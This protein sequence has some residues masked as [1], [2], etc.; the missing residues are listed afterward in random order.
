[1]P[2]PKLALAPSFCLGV[3]SLHRSRSLCLTGRPCP[4]RCPLAQASTFPA[5]GH[6]SL[7]D[8]TPARLP[9][10]PI[11][12]HCS[13]VSASGLPDPSGGRRRP[14]AARRARVPPGGPSSPGRPPAAAT[15][16]RPP[17]EPGAPRPRP[18]HHPLRGSGVTMGNCVTHTPPLRTASALPAART[19]RAHGRRE[20]RSWRLVPPPGAAHAHRGPFG[21]G[22]GGEVGAAARGSVIG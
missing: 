10:A 17:P 7:G 4:K 9:P 12:P 15:L 21:R 19:E 3:P 2:L 11:T 6:P 8:P 22:G 18:A 14:S 1:M 16:P 13:A 5:G 20:G